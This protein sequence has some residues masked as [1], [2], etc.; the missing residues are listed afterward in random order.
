MSK[1]DTAATPST[2][3]RPADCSES[4]DGHGA[5]PSTAA[6]NLVRPPPPPYSAFL[7]W[8]IWT[9]VGMVG[10]AGLFS[11]LTANIYF[12][13]IPTIADAFHES[14]ESINLTVTVYMIIQG[15]SPSIW[16]S[17]A[18]RKGRR[19]VFIICLLILLLCCVGLALTP[20]SDYWLLILLRCIQAAGS[21]STIA[22]SAGV[23]AD[24][25]PAEERG[26]YIGIS[27]IGPMIGPCLGPVIG[28][29]LADKLGWRSIFWFL[30]ISTGV[31]MIFMLLFFPET[32]RSQVG[33]GLIPAPKWNR[34]LIPIIGR[35]SLGVHQERPPPRPLPNP[36][37]LF[38]APDLMALLFSTAII[39]SAFYAVTATVSSLFSEHY[40]FLSETEI[41]LCYLSIGGGGAFATVLTGK[42]LDWQYMR[43]KTKF[44]NTRK[45]DLEKHSGS[46]DDEYSTSTHDDF[47]I[48][49]ATLQTQYIWILI[50]SGSCIGYGWCVQ[51]GT[52]IAGP[53]V[54]HFILGYTMV[55][56]MTNT[57]TLIVDLFPTQGSSVTAANNLVRCLMGAVAVSI[58][59]I[60]TNAI[61]A[62]W[63]Y[64]LCGLICLLTLPLVTLVLKKGPTWRKRRTERIR[65]AHS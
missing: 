29:L 9:I 11:P 53:L 56:V 47:P 18:D 36:F 58:I 26:G 2:G 23:I 64:T 28:G 37:K 44:E 60:I 52:S 48:E 19:V 5:G 13:A 24:I 15:L 51:S 21:A 34:P 12:P 38:T 10:L 20:T 7:P 3:E 46:L 59:N 25:I 65:Q 49:E 30:A 27:N 35:S 32:L 50:F 17:V 22:I 61:G 16:G 14:V 55:S 43:V 54:L 57:Q 39:Y 45:A 63:T 33:N 8:E 40:P 42:L 1:V 41:G 6:A 62:G 31:V 4:T